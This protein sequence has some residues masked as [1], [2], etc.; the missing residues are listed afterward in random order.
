M[1][2]SACG[3]QKERDAY[4][5]WNEWFA[6]PRARG[7]FSPSIVGADGDGVNVEGAAEFDAAHGQ[8]L[9]DDLI[10]WSFMMPVIAK[11]I[12]AG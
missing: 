12:A 10:R 5:V 4:A 9:L 7:R 1:Q 2:A 3:R 11:R 6:P 8:L